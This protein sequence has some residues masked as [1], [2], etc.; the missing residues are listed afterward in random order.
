[1]KLHY[2]GRKHFKWLRKL[3]GTGEDA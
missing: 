2:V 1:M 3:T